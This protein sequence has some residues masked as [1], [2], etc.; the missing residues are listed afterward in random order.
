M[1][2]L[3]ISLDVQSNKPLYEQI[4]SYLREEILK[5]NLKA[6][7]RLP[8]SRVLCTQLGVS[9]ST[10]DLA[11]EQLV[12][13]GYIETVP[14][15]GYYVCNV[16][17]LYH[18]SIENETQVDSEDHKKQ[19]CTCDFAINGVAPGGFPYNAWKKFSKAAM[20][21]GE[22]MFQT[23]DSCGEFTLRKAISE[24]LYHAR[25][26]QCSP[27]QIIVGAGNDYLLMLLCTILGNKHC[28]A[29]ENPAYDSAYRTIQR[30]EFKTKMISL[31]DKG[32]CVDE[33]EDSDADVVY[34]TPA[35]QFPTGVV[36]PITRRMQLLS[37]AQKGKRYIIEDDYDS[38]F[39]YRG[40]P[41]PALAGL[42]HEDKV[43]YLGTFSKSIA[44][45]IRISYMVLPKELMQAYRA[46]GKP[47][48][49]TVSRV[50]QKIIELF[51]QDG[52]YER[53]LNKM[54]AVYREKHDLLI[55]KLR[56]MSSICQYS[57]A[58]AGMHVLVHFTNRLTEEEAIARAKEAGIR[59]YGLSEYYIDKMQ[60]LP[61]H[62][63]LMGFATLENQ[64]IEQ[65]MEK[66]K[67]VWS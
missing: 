27:Q 13:E 43:I 61:S 24:Y 33:L 22:E 15:K 66:L 21:M 49:A 38:E 19:E 32:I 12:S 64:E 51:L 29:M 67:Q 7:E 17:G 36:M 48:S 60:M 1:N 46:Q 14:R 50:D 5:Q 25:G 6:G 53:H 8:S 4:Y 11:Y 28:V 56:E 57:G 40:K 39:R 23:G 59:V 45:T 55:G 37:W 62:T 26:V 58:D 42:D 31:D 9:R 35:H 3:L 52:Y 10:V 16:E 44:P 63:V 47:F 54:R 20:Q 18:I 30:L 34:V 2:T 65:A 41:I